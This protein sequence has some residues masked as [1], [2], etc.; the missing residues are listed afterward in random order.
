[1][2]DQ[3]EIIISGIEKYYFLDKKIPAVITAGIFLYK[4]YEALTLSRFLIR[5]HRTPLCSIQHPETS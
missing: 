1:M 4:F 5:I 2:E 3:E